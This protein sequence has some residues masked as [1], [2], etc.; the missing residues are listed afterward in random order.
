MNIN[1][2]RKK[3]ALIFAIVSL[4]V[5]GSEMSFDQ[6][7]MLSSEEF[8]AQGFTV[9]YAQILNDVYFKLSHIG[10][11]LCEKIEINLVIFDENER[12]IASAYLQAKDEGVDKSVYRFALS[13][14]QIDTSRL[15]VECKSS[16]QKSNYVVDMRE[17][18]DVAT[19]LKKGDKIN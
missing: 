13:V 7:K 6:I 12:L 15:D 5:C 18:R 9:E 11:D 1:F 14:N 16:N 19:Y 4:D 10:V 17:V 3:L 2:F 8:I